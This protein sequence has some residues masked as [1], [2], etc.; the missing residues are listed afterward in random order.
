MRP[1]VVINAAVLST[2]A[3]FPFTQGQFD[4]LCSDLGS[5]PIA[6]AVAASAKRTL[7]GTDRVGIL[8]HHQIRKDPL[9]GEEAFSSLPQPARQH[10]YGGWLASRNGFLWHENYSFLLHRSMHL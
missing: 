10:G 8:P 3:R 6:R 5:V 1:F 2:G 9:R 7:E 4:L